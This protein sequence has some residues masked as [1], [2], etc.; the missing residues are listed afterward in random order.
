MQ[1]GSE[2]STTTIV[3][4]LHLRVGGSALPSCRNTF[5]K[6]HL[7][8]TLP[9]PNSCSQHRDV[10]L[11]CLRHVPIHNSQ[12]QMHNSKQETDHFV[13]SKYLGYQ[14]MGFANERFD[15]GCRTSNVSLKKMFQTSTHHRLEHRYLKSLSNR[16]GMPAVTTILFC[17]H[18]R[19]G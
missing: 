15:Q 3:R 2:V 11:L 6:R 13:L 18:C 8:L 17:A 7:R 10:H 14:G 16:F 1:N 12:T 9:G 19:P 5:G 4:Y